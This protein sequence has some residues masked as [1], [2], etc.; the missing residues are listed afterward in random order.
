MSRKFCLFVCVLMIGCVESSLKAEELSTDT[1]ELALGQ[2]QSAA[3]VPAH[4]VLYD[5]VVVSGGP[6]LF[7]F[8]HSVLRGPRDCGGHRLN[9]GFYKVA[10]YCPPRPPAVS[11]RLQVL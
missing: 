8:S 2:S 1:A 10:E 7:G 3:C 11:R 9:R 4:E 5:D 6:D